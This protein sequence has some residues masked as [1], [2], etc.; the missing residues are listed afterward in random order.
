MDKERDHLLH[1]CVSPSRSRN[2]TMCPVSILKVLLCTGT[3][4]THIIIISALSQGVVLTTILPPGPWLRTLTPSHWFSLLSFC[5]LAE[6]K[7]LG[8]RGGNRRPSPALPSS[9]TAPTPPSQG[10]TS[11]VNVHSVAICLL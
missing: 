1:F 4:C 6:A 11:P 8:I 9:H 7:T 10:H 3:Q 2:H 5:T